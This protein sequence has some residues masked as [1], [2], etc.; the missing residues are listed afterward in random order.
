MKRALVTETYPPEVNGVAMT[1][2]RVVRGMAERGH[3]V[4]VVR[5]RQGKAAVPREDRGVTH[6]LVAGV[7]RPRYDGLR[8]GLPA[9]GRLERRWRDD[10][11]EVVHV[12]TEGPLG[13]SALWAA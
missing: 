7:P 13:I 2:E 3:R 8:F 12:A 4:E 10:P 6:V 9:R 1:L 5:P 11:P